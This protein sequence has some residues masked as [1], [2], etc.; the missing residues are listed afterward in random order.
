M[1]KVEVMMDEKALIAKHMLNLKLIKLSWALFFILIGGSWILESLQRID[2]SQKWALIYAG[3]GGILL[4]LNLLRVVWTTQY[5]KSNSPCHDSAFVEPPAGCLEARYKQVYHRAWRT[6][7][8]L[9][10]SEILCPSRLFDM[11]CGGADYRDFY[12]V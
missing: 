2:N 12:A 8:A 9:W 6:G 4:L 5:T 1:V 11:G 3:S 7:S 10:R